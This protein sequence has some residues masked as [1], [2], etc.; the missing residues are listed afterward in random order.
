MKQFTLFVGLTFCLD[1]TAQN[2]GIGT[3]VATRAKLE[4]HGAVDATTAIFGG[5]SSGV[6]FQRAWP[7]MG[8]N[9]YYDGGNRALSTGF[10]A[11]HYFDPSSGNYYLDML[12]STI[13]GQVMGSPRRA[14]SIASSGFCAVGGTTVPNSELQLPNVLGHRKLT[15]WESVNNDYQYYGFG[16]L[17][18]Q[19][20]YNVPGP[21]QAHKFYAGVDASNASV[22]MT[23]GGNKIVTIGDGT[24]NNSKLGVNLLGNPVTTVHLNGALAFSRASY[25][26]NSGNTF[27]DVGNNS[28]VH[29][30]CNQS[31]TPTITI[32]NGLTNGHILIIEAAPAFAFTIA[33]AGNTELSASHTLNG[34][35]ILMLMWSGTRWLEVNF[36]SN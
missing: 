20:I 13:A 17:S 3:T 34:A 29:I 11:K 26:V 21:S 25:I 23:I 5:E 24:V 9:M 36:S 1:C 28:Y 16:I 4:L 35:D 12:P 14:L 6:S 32:S 10:G 8:F 33:D 22:L 7:G 18:G 19:L 15:L 27:V 30:N 31:G 2:V